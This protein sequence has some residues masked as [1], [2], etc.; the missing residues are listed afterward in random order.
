MNDDDPVTRNYASSPCY[1]QELDPL[2]RDLAGPDGETWRDVRRWRKAERERLLTLRST[3]NSE[4]RDSALESIC[5]QLDRFLQS[6]AIS[7]LGAYWPMHG[8][9]DLRHWMELQAD[10]GLTIALP[11]ICAPDLPL[12]YSRWQPQG[13]MRRG[14]WG[15]AE[16]FDNDWVE[17]QMVLV[18]LL[19]V[20]PQQHRLGYGGGYFDRSLAAAEPNR[21]A[22][23]I[24][25]N[26]ARIATIYAQ[27]HDIPMDRVITG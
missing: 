11:I 19:G 14:A 10:K 20:D 5:E 27:A 6:S 2:Y 15:I 1:A 21:Q 17:P 4:Q 16:P 3:L 8:E 12:K 26:C 23:G 25:F 13:A 22:V 24:G 7:V 18:P 9:L